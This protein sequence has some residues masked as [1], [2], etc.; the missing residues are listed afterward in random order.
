MKRPKRPFAQRFLACASLRPRWPSLRRC[1]QVGKSLIY[2]GAEIVSPGSPRKVLTQKLWILLDN[3]LFLYYFVLLLHYISEVCFR[4]F[5]DQDIWWSYISKG[6]CWRQNQAYDKVMCNWGGGGKEANI[7]MYLLSME[8]YCNES[9]K[10][11]SRNTITSKL[12]THKRIQLRKIE[13][14]MFICQVFSFTLLVRQ[15]E[16]LMFHFIVKD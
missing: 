8:A 5:L 6:L 4:Y 2:L 9:S 11:I 13:I 12:T 14:S 1:C 10:R 15:I 3:V 7:I 16:S